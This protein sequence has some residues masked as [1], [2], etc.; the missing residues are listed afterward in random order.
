MMLNNWSLIYKHKKCGGLNN[1]RISTISQLFLIIILADR[2]AASKGRRSLDAELWSRRGKCRRRYSHGSPLGWGCWHTAAAKL[3]APGCPRGQ[4]GE[5][6]RWVPF[7]AYRLPCW[8]SQ[9]RPCGQRVNAILIVGHRGCGQNFGLYGYP[10]DKFGVRIPLDCLYSRG[11]IP[12]RESLIRFSQY[13][14]RYWSTALINW[15]IEYP[16][17]ET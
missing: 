7:S 13:Q 17:Q 15:S 11:L 10:A 2:I 5:H 1:L 16:T 12:P 4:H 9:P 3:P 14:W 8:R 6:S